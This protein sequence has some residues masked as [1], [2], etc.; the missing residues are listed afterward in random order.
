MRLK[1]LEEL[2]KISPILSSV[3]KVSAVYDGKEWCIGVN[4]W[5]PHD[6]GYTFYFEEGDLNKPLQDLLTEILALLGEQMR[7]D[8]LI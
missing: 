6:K 4:Y 5:A 7:K 8:G 2:Y 1:M 3:K